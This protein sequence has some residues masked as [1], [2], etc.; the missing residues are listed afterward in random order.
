[1]I[2]RAPEIEL[3]E[4]LRLMTRGEP[5]FHA[6]PR[7]SYAGYGRFVLLNVLKLLGMGRG[8]RILVP[9]YICDV[10][11]L[12]FAELGIEPVYYGITSDFQVDWE[13]VAVLPGTRAFISVNY[14][15]VSQDYRAVAGFT[16]R[17]GLLW[18]NDNA[19]GFAG[20]LDGT[21]LEEFGDISFTSFRKVLGSLNGARV[22]INNENL[23]YLKERLDRLNGL[24]AAQPRLRHLVAAGLRTAGL[25][26]RPL[27]DFSDP[28]GFRD[29]DL[30][31]YR[32]DD[33][34]GRLLAQ[35]DEALIRLA[36]R[37]LYDD[38]E[39]FIVSG[40]CRTMQP[41]PGLLREGNS[42]LVLPVVAPDREAWLELLRRS[43]ALGLDLHTWPS[44]PEPVLRDNIHGAADLWGRML[45]LPL[46]QGLAS[47]EY[48]P[49]LQRVLHAA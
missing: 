3:P 7:T 14:F 10:L 49:L 46:H 11:L 20:T 25:R 31:T 9:A 44:L 5:Q 45:Y 40:A 30:K 16:Q 41:I 6:A 29:G 24:A 27:P 32:L 33:A 21:S 35:S 8:D 42:P 23:T 38:L 34:S 37:S 48:L 15:G 13:T 26:L 43:R 17:H 47:S 19:H 36:R 12:P 1:M 2:K 39:R 28:S 22:R 18:I 4:L